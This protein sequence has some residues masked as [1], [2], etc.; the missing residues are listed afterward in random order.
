MDAFKNDEIVRME[1]GGNRKCREFFEQAPEFQK[2][3]TIAERYSSE[4]AEDY[5]EKVRTPA[6]G[7]L[8]ARSLTWPAHG[9]D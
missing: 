3:M 7:P 5:K 1:K 9:R 8:P 2:S 6:D 4:F